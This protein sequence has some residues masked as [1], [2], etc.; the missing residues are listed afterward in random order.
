V[1]PAAFA[2]IRAGSLDEALRA[3]ADPEAKAVAGGHSLIP[4]MK[5][6]IARPSLL[7]DLRDLDLRT[8]TVGDETVTIGALATYDEV[9]RALAGVSGVDALR[10]CAASVGDLQV[11][12]AGTLGGGVAHGDPASDIA[13]GVLALGASL[14]LQAAEGT[15]SVAADDFFLGP[16]TTEL[17]QQELLV[18]VSVPRTGP[19][20]GSAYTAV[21]DAASGYPLA[22]AAVVVGREGDAVRSCRIAI[23]GLTGAP[24]RL[25]G[26]EAAVVR[27]GVGADIAAA[28]ADLEPATDDAD[29][30]RH[31]AAVVI[32]RA[33][34]QAWERAGERS[35]A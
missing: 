26:A 31:L 9:S 10:E 11:R 14:E 2:Y 22:G 15:R 24:Q 12:N 27:D 4:A 29:Y 21:E 5:T 7:V 28:I 1:I 17:R 25:P 30:R 20:A 35:N 8:I 6:R 34:R 13:A 16:F 33:L 32:A 18:E 19:A 3:L 23:T